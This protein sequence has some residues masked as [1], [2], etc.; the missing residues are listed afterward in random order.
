MYVCA[1]T[2]RACSGKYN[3]ML[4]ECLGSTVGGGSWRTMR[5]V[6]TCPN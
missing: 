2:V 3:K 4:W 5:G 6:E 1:V